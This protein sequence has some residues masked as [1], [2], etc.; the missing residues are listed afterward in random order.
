MEK[1]T[2]TLG[3][4]LLLISV[5]AF[6]G[7]PNKYITL[8]NGMGCWVTEHGHVFGCTGGPAAQN[9]TPSTCMELDAALRDI[10]NQ[11]RSGYSARKGKDLRRKRDDYEDLQREYCR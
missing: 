11:L 6:A 10:N 5:T 3:I 9:S 7:A 8:P 1:R 4:C 2:T